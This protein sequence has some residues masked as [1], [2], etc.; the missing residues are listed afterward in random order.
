MR[1]AGEER[2]WLCVSEKMGMR[3]TSR[4]EGKG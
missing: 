3:Y 2:A 1:A 4:S